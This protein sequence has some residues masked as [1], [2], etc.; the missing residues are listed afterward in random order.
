MRT[1]PKLQLTSC[2]GYCAD[3]N[4]STRRNLV[5]Y[6]S[7]MTPLEFF[8]RPKTTTT[9]NYCKDKKMPFG[10]RSLLGLGLKYAIKRP[11][12]TNKLGSTM[13]RLR[14]DVR[15]ISFFK[16]NPPEE[17]DDA[18]PR[19]IPGLYIKSDWEPPEARG[20]IEACLN[21][22]EKELRIQQSAYNR[23]TPSNL[24]PDQWYLVHYRR[25]NDECIIIEADKNL[26]VALCARA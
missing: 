23:P 14:R 5:Q 7:Q 24:I 13:E 12:P 3:P 17:D 9:H 8:S 25:R 6:V 20:Y 22:F 1:I 16:E 26:G 18:K 10:T 11:R 19:Y 2:F 15:R 21:N 4:I